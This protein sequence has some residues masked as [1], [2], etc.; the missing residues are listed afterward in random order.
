MYACMHVTYAR[1]M[2]G[3][4]GWIGWMDGWM[5]VCACVRTCIALYLCIPIYTGRHLRIS[6]TS[7]P[8]EHG[9]ADRCSDNWPRVEHHRMM[10]PRQH[11]GLCSLSLEGLPL[12]RLVLLNP[13]VACRE[14]AADP[15]YSILQ[16]CKDF[17]KRSALRK[18]RRLMRTQVCYGCGILWAC[19]GLWA[20]TAL[21]KCGVPL[22]RR[23]RWLECTLT[24]PQ[25]VGK[26]VS[27][28]VSSQP[29]SSMISARA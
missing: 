28:P 24:L 21:T 18:N 10:P 12:G 3:W 7:I 14:Q 4:I 22:G 11:L 17:R 19:R 20:S 5:D 6:A 9:K 16:H 1:W 26:D 13:K 29:H 27:W 2:D 15:N 25:A 23:R 8:L